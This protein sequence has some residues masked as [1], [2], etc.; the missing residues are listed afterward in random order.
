MLRL[1]DAAIIGVIKRVGVHEIETARSRSLRWVDKI[2]ND[3]EGGDGLPYSRWDS[4]FRRMTIRD[5]WR[6]TAA[7]GMHWRRVDGEWMASMA[8]MVAQEGTDVESPSSAIGGSWG[9]LTQ[10]RTPTVT[11]ARTQFV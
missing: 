11:N 1:W 4:R 10:E 7:E 3:G 6:G 2:K 5:A 8:T 9:R